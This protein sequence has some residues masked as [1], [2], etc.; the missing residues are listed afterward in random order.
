MP[1]PGI[2]DGLKTVGGAAGKGLL[3]LAEM[4]SAGT[5]AQGEYTETVARA[6]LAHPDF[7]IGFISVNPASW[8]T[9][10]P[11]GLIHMTPGVQLEKGGDALGQQYNTPASVLGERG[12]D[13][14]I[15]GRG[16]IKAKDPAEAAEEYRKAGWEAYTASLQ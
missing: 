8:K 6:A 4:S 16:V 5:L 11:P 14:I 1:G 7:V 13:V 10:L 3:L 9:H 15:V 12:S 2:I